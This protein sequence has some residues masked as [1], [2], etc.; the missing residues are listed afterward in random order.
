[1]TRMRAWMTG[2]VL[3]SLAALILVSGTGLAGDDEKAQQAQILKIAAALKTNKEDGQKMAAA[4]AKTQKY[5]SLASLEPIM[6]GFKVRKKGGFGVGKTPG[7]VTPDGIE[8]KINEL[9]RDGVTATALAK[10]AEAIEEL[11]YVS[12]AIAEVAKH[13]ETKEFKGKMSKKDFVALAERM[14]DGAYKL[15]GAA[16]KKGAAEIKSAA[17]LVNEACNACHSQFRK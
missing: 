7:A 9:Q 4:M 10:Q 15:A 1:M 16:N 6:H 11:A 14:A 12:A 2:G 3:L 8:L 17:K 13:L 5:D